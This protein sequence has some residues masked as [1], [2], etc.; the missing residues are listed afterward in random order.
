MQRVPIPDPPDPVNLLAELRDRG[1]AFLLQSAEGPRRLAR[2]SFLGFQPRSRLRVDE[3]TARVDGDAIEAPPT[4]APRHL[5]EG[6]RTDADDGYAFNGGLVGYWSYEYATLLESLPAPEEHPGPIGAFPQAELGLFL[7]GVIYDHE[8]RNCFYFTQA[9]DRS[10][11]LPLASARDGRGD[12][13]FHVGQIQTRPPREAFTGQVEDLQ[14]YIDEGHTFQT[15]LSRSFQASYEGSLVDAY[16]QL[17]AINPS[18]YMFFLSLGE[19]DVFGASPEML[20]RV[21]D[22]TIET[23]PIAGTRPLGDTPAETKA[24]EEEMT[25]SAK[26]RAEHAMLVDLARNDVGRVARPGTVSVEQL[27]EVE[28]YS[29]VQHMVSRVA[30]QLAEDRDGLDA[31]H[32]LFPAGTV[33]GAPKIRAMELVAELEAA[34]RGPYAGCIGYLGLNGNLDSAI[35]I[36]SAWAQNDHVELRAGAGIVADSDAEREFDETQAKGEAMLDALAGKGGWT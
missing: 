13:P 6:H 26:E 27:M 21:E 11:E 12:R 16:R 2:Y 22:G 10:D 19:R 30:G 33:S 8:R 15:V 7:D 3:A 5:L 35:T 29:H 25:S 4:H 24:Y 18:P 20:V 36:R 9:E 28:R 31:L 1:D 32:A 17:L 14:T 34:R 23:D